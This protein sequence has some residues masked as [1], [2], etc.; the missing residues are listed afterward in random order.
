MNRAEYPALSLYLAGT[1]VSRAG[2]E[3]KS[4]IN[5]ASDEVLGE[6]PYATPEDIDLAVRSA[7]TAFEKWR[8]LPALE[9]ASI[10]K[11]AA[12]LVRQRTDAIAR[13][14]TL[15]EG[16]TLPE[17]RRETGFAADIFE[18]FAEEGKR[19]Y[20]RTVPARTSGVRQTVIREPV[21]PVAAFSPWN[22]PAGAPA[23]KIAAALAAGCSCVIKPAEETPNTALQLALALHDAGLPAGVLSVVFGVPSEISAALIAR[24]EIRKISFTGSFSVGKLLAKLAAD[25]LK[26][27]TMELGGH[28]PVIVFDD[29]DMEEAAA[30]CATM[31]YRNAG[32]ICISPTRFYVHRAGYE[33]FVS[34]FVSVAASIK[35]GDGMDTTVTMGPLANARRLDAMRDLIG[36]AVDS[37]A[38]LAAGGS[39]IGNRGFFWQPTVLADVPADARIMKEEPFGPVACIRPF[40]TDEEAITAANSLPYGLAA[41]AFTH[42]SKKAHSASAALQAGLVGI[43]GFFVSTPETPFGGVKQSGYGSEG[44]SEGLDAYLTTKFISHA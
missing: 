8:G 4:V 42:S 20:G 36:D 17:A 5:P 7:A 18:W 12:E 27:V 15:E 9:R 24:P 33:K 32:Q 11:R 31:K 29:A 23:L 1:F 35:V 43:N 37:G 22:F 14:L 34:K 10:L 40:D 21:G 13:I 39:R 6:L 41:Y 19:I 30:A 16:K 26:R 44:G 2:R 38:Q 3:T 25:D 28:A